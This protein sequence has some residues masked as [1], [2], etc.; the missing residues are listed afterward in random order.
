MPP[1]AS[2]RKK[3][4]GNDFLYSAD[5]KRMLCK[6]CHPDVV[7]DEDEWIGAKDAVGEKHL[8]SDRHRKAVRLQAENERFARQ[9]E[10]ERD[11]ARGAASSELNRVHI[12]PEYLAGPMAESSSAAWE[13]EW[14]E[15]RLDGATG[16]DFGFAEDVGPQRT[17]QDELRE[18]FEG[19]GV[20]DV[21]ETA[22]RLGFDHAES[23][24]RAREEDEDEILADI[25]RIADLIDHDP[26]GIKAALGET[27]LPT[28]D[29]DWFPYPSKLFFLLDII[30]NLPRLRLSS[31]LLHMFIFVLKEAKCRDTVPSYDRFREFQKELRVQCGIPTLPCRSPMCNVFFM[32]N[33]Q[34]IIANDYVNP[35][36]RR[37]LNFYP[38][39]RAD[40]AVREFYQ[41]G[42]LVTEMDLDAL[43]PMYDAGGNV[44]YY[45][46]EVARLKD[47]R[48]IIPIRWVVFNG[49]V[50]ADVLAIELDDEGRATVISTPSEIRVSVKNFASNFHDLEH[51]S[52]IPHWTDATI[53]A[54]Y[55]S[56]MPNPKRK[57][58]K[59]RPLYHSFVDYFGDDVSGNR[60]KAWNKHYNGYL[61][62]RNLPRQLLL[63]IGP[64]HS[65][66]LQTRR[67]LDSKATA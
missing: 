51:A 19:F 30:D 6:T 44:H 33:V 42:K 20:W 13:R 36:T 32:N 53:K 31:A 8:N 25:L 60:S 62:H 54:G 63:E 39:I 14:E 7:G 17:V 50:H 10:D 12:H 48:Y 56:R 11:M 23:I 22:R 57:I 61:T 47:G 64:M 4:L 27:Q 58:A 43:S 5:G 66:P 65:D 38:E 29:A 15:L 45:V 41:P 9:M 67:G 28:T 35:T 49:V 16:A 52:L 55:P 46:N 26:T 2:G 21:T 3:N 18:G 59:G 37:L 1:R 34:Q 24:P 40:G